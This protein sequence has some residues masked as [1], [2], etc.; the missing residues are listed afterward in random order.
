MRDDSI[1]KRLHKYYRIYEQI[2]DY[3]TIP[4]YQITKN[5][6]ISRSTVSRYLMEM[7]ENGILKGPMIFLK[8]NSTNKRYALFCVFDDP[9]TVYQGLEGFPRVVSRALCSGRWNITAISESLLNFSVLKGFRQCVVQGP[10]GMTHLPR[11]PLLEWDA[12][13]ES[14]Y[15]QVASPQTP[16]TLNEHISS[17]SWSPDEWTLYHKFK[18]NIR[19]QAV[20]ILKSCNI[21][22]E[23]YQAWN[24]ELDAYSCIQPAFY[25]RG[26]EHYFFL[27]FLFESRYHQQL[28]SLLGNLP[29]TSIFF[30][31][32]THLLARIPILNKKE[33]DDLFSLIFHLGKKNYF[34][35]FYQAL[36]ISTSVQV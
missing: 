28:V 13:I 14:I 10:K 3:P 1:K 31:V 17:I 18:Y 11:V 8:P 26:I 15:N 16:S 20:S 29:A 36:L 32:D 22:Y 4:L 33:K 2:Y 9:Y 7:Y 12:A 24:R 6:R 35:T 5:T 27:D 34:T 30:S 25:P 21:R 23:K 19:M